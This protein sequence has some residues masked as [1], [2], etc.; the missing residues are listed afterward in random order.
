MCFLEEIVIGRHDGNLENMLLP[1]SRYHLVS[2]KLST[3]SLFRHTWPSSEVWLN[4]SWSPWVRAQI[5][6]CPG[7]TSLSC[8]KN[9]CRWAS[10]QG[11]SRVEETLFILTLWSESGEDPHRHHVLYK[12]DTHHDLLGGP[13]KTVLPYPLKLIWPIRWNKMKHLVSW[14]FAPLPP[15]PSFRNHSFLPHFDRASVVPDGGRFRS[16]IL[17]Y[18]GYLG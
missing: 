15:S 9:G 3:G 12:S 7:A 18:I 13:F 1:W 2:Q 8:F 6:C 16:W 14:R 11:S 4:V 17:G 10:L 5:D